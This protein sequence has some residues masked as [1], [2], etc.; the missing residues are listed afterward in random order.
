[1]RRGDARD[2][3]VDGQNVPLAVRCAASVVLSTH[4]VLNTTLA[5]GEES[6]HRFMLTSARA[7]GRALR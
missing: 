4:D 5:T 6:A 7:R 3:A 2:R 1:L